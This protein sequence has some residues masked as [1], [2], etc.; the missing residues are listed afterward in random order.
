MSRP[1]IVFMGTPEFAV[2]SLEIL[3]KHDYP[4]A[5]V[6]TQPDRP[7]GRGRH[8]IPSPVK[9]RA[10][11]HRLP[12]LQPERARNNDFI[13]YLRICAPDLVVVAAFG[14]IL[15]REILEIPQKGC[16]NVHPSLLPKYRGA[17]PINWAII[18][19]EEKTGIT[20]M[21]MDEGMDTGDIL[22]QEETRIAPEETSGELHNRLAEMGAALLL[23]TTEMILSGAGTRTPQDASLATYAPRLKKEDGLIRWDTEVHHIVNLI[24]GFSPVPG[25]YSFLRG[26]MLKI[27]SATGEEVSLTDTPGIIGRETENGLPVA[28]RNGYVW[29]REIQLE[30]KKRMP[31]RDFLRGF[32]ISP[33]D[34]LG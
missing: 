16:V 22:A 2:P 1:K 34:V 27:F 25:A 9:A 28:A 6:V 31:V 20:I 14:Q 7:K 32:S 5:A 10:Q 23:R 17:A 3:I 8:M 24:R 13:E 29:L 12:V 19:G 33:G 26:K 21:L 11:H 18:R 15:P 30:N 4:I